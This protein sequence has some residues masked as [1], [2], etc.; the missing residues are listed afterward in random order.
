MTESSPKYRDT[1]N[2]W[3]CRIRAY[4]RKK[5]SINKEIKSAM[6]GMKTV[7]EKKGEIKYQKE[8][9]IGSGQKKCEGHLQVCRPSMYPILLN[10]L[11]FYIYSFNQQM[12]TN[13][14]R[15]T[16]LLKR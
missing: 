6:H 1:K 11:Y 10:P 2:S 3:L 15:F 4:E 7:A 13:I 12:H 16:I 14:I 8:K 5:K 9:G